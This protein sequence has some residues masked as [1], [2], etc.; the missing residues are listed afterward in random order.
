MIN[1]QWHHDKWWQHTQTYIDMWEYALPS[2]RIIAIIVWPDDQYTATNDDIDIYWHLIKVSKTH[3]R[4]AAHFSY[5]S[6][7]HSNCVT[8]D[9]YYNP[10]GEW[11]NFNNSIRHIC[12]YPK[13]RNKPT[14]LSSAP[15][16]RYH[17]STWMH[18]NKPFPLHKSTTPDSY[19]PNGRERS[20]KRIP[21]IECG[22][23]ALDL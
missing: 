17:Q 15:C 20:Q 21:W 9:S 22:C 3:F 16:Y 14:M 4:I 12:V 1:A 7:H 2:Y 6:V 13:L 10:E 8:S 19:N 11:Q 23:E 5:M 18:Y